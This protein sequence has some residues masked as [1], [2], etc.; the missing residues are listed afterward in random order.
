MV[1]RMRHNR[2]QRK[3]TRSHHALVSPRFFTCNDCKAFHLCHTV[4]ETCGK[5]K[6]RVV[7]DVI[8]KKEK[9]QKKAEIATKR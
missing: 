3:N 4:C 1:V 2:S 9:K 6:G 5:Y 8:A 7:I